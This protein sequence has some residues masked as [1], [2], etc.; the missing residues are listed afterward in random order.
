MAADSLNQDTDS[1]LS[2]LRNAFSKPR[3]RPPNEERVA[4]RK[5]FEGFSCSNGNALSEESI[6]RVTSIV[7]KLPTSEE[8][9][10]LLLVEKERFDKDPSSFCLS[11]WKPFDR[12]VGC[13]AD[14]VTVIR[15]L[16]NITETAERNYIGIRRRLQPRALV[17]VVRDYEAD[18]MMEPQPYDRG[19]QDVALDDLAARLWTEASEQRRMREKDKLRRKIVVG[20]RCNVLPSGML[21][22]LGDSAPLRM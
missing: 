8:D 1:G 10:E 6:Q 5:F 18:I 22:G 11:F 19:Y 2:V 3:P 14:H 13:D 21:F 17:V 12:P 20:E 9:E 4:I 15:G 16:L 7:E